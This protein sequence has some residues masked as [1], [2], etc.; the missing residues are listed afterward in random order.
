MKKTFFVLLLILFPFLIKAQGFAGNNVQLGFTLTPNTGW[1]RFNDSDPGTSSNGGRLGFS[2][3]VLGD[4]GIAGNT[5]YYFSTAFTL[6]TVNGKAATS[7][8]S[9]LYP[10]ID[11]TPSSADYIY[12][13]Q[14]IEVPITLKLKSNPS[15]MGRFYGQFG[16]GTAVKIGAKADVSTGMTNSSAG[17]EDVNVSKE[18]N[19][20]RLSLIAGAGA[21]WKLDNNLDLQ[22]GITFNNGFTDVFDG[23]GNARS[24]YIAFNLGIFF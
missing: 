4:F 10:A 21:E 3:G 1:L 17:M 11:P 16:L 8:P 13:L 23:D 24:S 12:K 9:Q 7:A 22:T 6:T 20:F 5:N 15:D 2:Y 18:I 14:Y 19:N